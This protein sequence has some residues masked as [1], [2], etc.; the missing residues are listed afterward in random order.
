MRV[1][2]L[3]GGAGTA[4][5]VCGRG[6]GAARPP[7][8]PGAG[9]GRGFDGADAEPVG[10]VLEGLQGLLVGLVIILHRGESGGPRRRRG[11]SGGGTWGWAGT[12]ALRE[13]CRQR[14]SAGPCGGGGERE[15]RGSRPACA[16]PGRAHR[17]GRPQERRGGAGPDRAARPGLAEPA[18]PPA[19]ASWRLRAPAPGRAQAPLPPFPSP[20]WQAVRGRRGGGGPSEPCAVSGRGPEGGG[21]EPA[22]LRGKGAPSRFSTI[23]TL[24]G[25]A[26]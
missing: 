7:H 18:A 5:P 25:K 2:M 20:A 6:W 26:G 22:G 3:A 15:G 9:R 11:S 12:A 16:G 21:L 10:R 4:G 14:A 17:R 1:G 8:S 19:G 24:L 23:Q 13:G